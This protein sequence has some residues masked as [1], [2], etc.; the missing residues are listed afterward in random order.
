M[1]E[2]IEMPDIEDVLRLY[3][4]SVIAGV[5]TYAGTTPP[6]LSGKSITSVRTGGVRRDLVVDVPTVAV[7][8]RAERLGD[9]IEMAG[10]TRSALGMAEQAGALGDTV[11][12]ELVEA[13]GPYANPDP[14]HP[15]LPRVSAVYQIA[16]RGTV[17]P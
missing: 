5:S 15:T 4:A 11:M 14:D 9:A 16:V 1:P 6:D 17:F 3:F 8:C 12:Y 13:S 7:H 2:R 10:E